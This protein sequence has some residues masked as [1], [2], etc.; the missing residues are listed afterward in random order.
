M[1]SLV[2]I[3]AGITILLI[4]NVLIYLI[5]WATFEKMKT[6]INF[7]DYYIREEVLTRKRTHECLKNWLTSSNENTR[8]LTALQ[9]AMTVFNGRQDSTFNIVR[10]IIGR[11]KKEDKALIKQE[12][13]DLQERTPETDGFLMTGK[14]MDLLK[15][16]KNHSGRNQVW[17]KY[18]WKKLQ[19]KPY[20][21]EVSTTPER[22]KQDRRQI[23][24]TAYV[25]GEHV[26][27]EISEDLK[28][29]IVWYKRE[30]DKK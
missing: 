2:F 27:C 29:I 17:E 1:R 8:L 24:N 18:P 7:L 25:H 16:K 19:T 13:L 4:F 12:T 5:V 21:F 9:K 11:V 14:A 28:T 3:S 23:S 20:N 10:G 6:Y 26:R 22:A 15:P 30:H